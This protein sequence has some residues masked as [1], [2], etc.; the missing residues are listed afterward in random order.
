MKNLLVK[1]PLAPSPSKME[2]GKRCWR[3]SFSG[4]LRPDRA[5]LWRICAVFFLVFSLSLG[6]SHC[7]WLYYAHGRGSYTSL[8]L[9]YSF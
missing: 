9:T 2:R 4:C 7:R 3:M 8:L 5:Q 1:A 6:F